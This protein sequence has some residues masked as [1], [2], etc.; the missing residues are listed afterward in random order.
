MS[1][2]ESSLPRDGKAGG[3]TQHSRIQFAQPTLQ[4]YPDELPCS[5]HILKGTRMRVKLES[6]W[7]EM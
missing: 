5:V 3:R 7:K 4:T 6:I 2:K 1:P